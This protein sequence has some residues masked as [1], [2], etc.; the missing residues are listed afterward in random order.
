[1]VFVWFIYGL[2]FFVLGLVVIVYPKK[3]SAFKLAD[4]LWLIAGFGI[5]HGINEWIDMFIVIE[6]PFPVM[7]LEL[8]GIAIL[9]ISFLFLVQFGTTVIAEANNKLRFIRI[10]PVV[11]FLAWAIIFLL[12]SRRLLIG[13]IF[14][15]YLI[16]VPGT[17]LTAAALFMHIPQFKEIKLHRVTRSLLIAG[18]VFLIYGTLAGIIVHGAEFFPANLINYDWFMSIFGAPVQIF[19]AICA[20]VLACANIQILSVFR[21]ETQKAQ[22]ELDRYRSEMEKKTWLA[23]VGTM[24]SIM[25]QKLDEPLAVTRLLLQRVLMDLG[26]TSSDDNVTKSLKKS[27][28]EVSKATD[29]VKRLQSTTQ[30]SDK[31]TTEPVDLYQI[32]KRIM[33]VFAQSTQQANLAL[34]VKDVD[35]VLNLSIPTHQLEQVFFILVQ[36]AINRGGINKQQ[37]LTISCR[38]RDK[39]VEL[40]F[41]DTCRAIEQEELPDIFEPFFTTAPG[42]KETGLG[43]AVAKRIICDHGGDITVESRPGQTTFHVTL[44]VE[45]M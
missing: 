22:E 24:S 20:I 9:P 27:L 33:A 39:H 42:T 12:S 34:S 19:R 6:E 16:C 31:I 36:N 8:I 29:I 2:A 45:Q 21:W 26:E 15:R 44:P 13:Q 17:F 30:V 11:L 40:T 28:S 25:A 35:T 4:N 5:L 23:E 3:G 14:A 18:I 38:P 10:L 1:M 43:L 41:A 37:K 7:A 32:T